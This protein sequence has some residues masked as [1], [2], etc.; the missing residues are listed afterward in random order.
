MPDSLSPDQAAEIEDAPDVIRAGL[1]DGAGHA[2]C[3]SCRS[4]M[5]RAHALIEAQ[6]A[7]IARV[8]ADEHQ[9]W[10]HLKEAQ[11]KLSKPWILRN[12]LGWGRASSPP[13]AVAEEQTG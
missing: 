3:E 10:R 1:L 6:A 4:V 8:K 9:T 12:W 13:P 2:T 5:R 7:V 11:R